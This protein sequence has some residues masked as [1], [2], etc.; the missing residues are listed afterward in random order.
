MRIPL[1]HRPVLSAALAAGLA[2]GCPPWLAASTALLVAWCAAAAVHL[3]LSVRAMA[4]ATP[5]AARRRAAL[6]DADKW[7]TLG[8]SLSA[9]IASLGAVAV[10]LASTPTDDVPAGAAVLATGAVALSWAF[11]HVL[12]AHHYM[13]EYWRKG[14]EASCSPGRN[15]PAPATSCTSPSRS[16]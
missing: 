13:H 9:A 8:G 16:A 14:G 4:L 3:A 11:V 1:D 2:A 6:L 12:L 10:D 5:E 7:A 15:D